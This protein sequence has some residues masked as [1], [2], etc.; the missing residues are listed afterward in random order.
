MLSATT[1]TSSS[2]SSSNTAS[3]SSNTA[4]SSTSS[5]SGT[6]S[7]SVPPN[8]AAAAATAAASTTGGN[9]TCHKRRAVASLAPPDGPV[10]AKRARVL[11][12][13]LA[14]VVR[15]SQ[16]HWPAWWLPFAL[17]VPRLLR[18][19]LPLSTW[20]AHTADTVRVIEVPR[21][22]PLF[23]HYQMHLRLSSDIAL[24]WPSASGGAPLS[25]VVT[26]GFSVEIARV[27]QIQHPLLWRR[28]CECRDT[29]QR[30]F[31]AGSA[32]T[33]TRHVECMP[34]WHGTSADSLWSIVQYGL[35]DAAH[36]SGTLSRGHMIGQRLGPGI[37][38]TPV[39][40]LAIHYA[41]R[42]AA[43]LASA[44]AAS[45][46]LLLLA[47][48]V[49][50]GRCALVSTEA[51]S[52]TPP[53]CPCTDRP[54][55]WHAAGRSMATKVDSLTHPL[56]YCSPSPQRVYVEAVLFIRATSL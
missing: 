3:S 2:A 27:Y 20:L 12:Q 5:T 25:P 37:Y 54:P 28:Y 18:D 13:P 38:T 30:E 55:A 42:R 36:L 43:G 15:A 50:I 46:T 14:V 8:H 19:T 29:I 51:A 49:V 35:Q 45:N 40:A 16:L 39:S 26:P 11:Q 22:A 53:Q 41:R 56:Q 44:S 24:A 34:L 10:L 21:H 48:R 52:S 33:A 1:P 6:S 17:P 31:A 23:G 9:R 4:S 32:E 7:T 47:C